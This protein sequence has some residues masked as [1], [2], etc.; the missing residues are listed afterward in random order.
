LNLEW[1]EDRTLLSGDTL[2]TATSIKFNADHAT[3]LAGALAFQLDVELVSMNLVA[4]DTVTTAVKPPKDG[5]GFDSYVRVFNP[6][7]KE[8]AASSAYHGKDPGLTFQAPSAGTYF[9]GI[10]DV[11]NTN[12]DPTI[13]PPTASDDSANLSFDLKLSKKK[14]PLLP[15]LVGRSFHIA[16]GAVVW[17]DSVT[18]N[19]EIENRGGPP[20]GPFHVELRLSAD[21]HIDSDAS[22]P[23]VTSWRVSALAAGAMTAGTLHVTLPATPEQSSPDITENGTFYLGL[24]IDP[25]NAVQESDPSSSA[26]Q[27]EG[28]DRGALTVL[29]AVPEKGP[30]NTTSDA[31]ALF[32]AAGP[33]FGH[34]RTSRALGPNEAA[35]YQFTAGTAAQLTAQ[36][37]ASG[38]R[39]RLSLLDATGQL[40][41]QSDGQSA[42]NPESIIQLYLPHSAKGDTFYLR[43]QWLAGGTGTYVF[44]TQLVPGSFPFDPLLP[45]PAFYSAVAIGDFNGDGIPDLAIADEFRNPS[46]G[47]PASIEL[48]LGNKDASGNPDG[49]F[50]DVAPL[51]L[52]VS[53]Q[54]KVEVTALVAGDFIGNGRSDL[55]AAVTD[56][57]TGSAFLVV[58]LARGDGT[59]KEL[60]QLLLGQGQPGDGA[61]VFTLGVGDL[62]GDG[63]PDL[64]VV[65][66]A[67]DSIPIDLLFGN[68]D[69]TFREAP[70]GPTVNG[71]IDAL[72]VGSVYGDGHADLVAAVTTDPVGGSFALVVLRGNGNGTFMAAPPIS[73]PADSGQPVALAAADF[74]GSGH[75]DLAIAL[76][77]NTNNDQGTTA[78]QV[79]AGNG[80]GTFTP[81]DAYPFPPDQ[82]LDALAAG[83]FNGDGLT[84]LAVVN[85]AGSSSQYGLTL[86]QGKGDGSFQNGAFV[87]AGKDPGAA[88]SADFNGDGRPDLAIA[89]PL[90]H[91]IN[92]FLGD[93]M[94]SF[95]PVVPYP[96]PASVANDVVEVTALVA[97]DFNG[98]GHPD[99][100]ATIKDDTTH[101]AY[102]AVLLGQGDGSFKLSKWEALAGDNP[103]AVAAGDFND[104]GFTDLAVLDEASRSIEVLLGSLDGSLGSLK[105]FSVGRD[106]IALVAGDF[107]GRHFKDGTPIL[108]LA[109]ADIAGKNAVQVLLGGGD[110]SFQQGESIPI[111]GQPRALVTG[112][113]DDSHD[114]DGTPVLDLAV[115]YQ[116]LHPAKNNSNAIQVLLGDGHGSFSQAKPIAVQG[117][118]TVLVA[119]DFTGRYY[120][121]GTPVLD[122]VAGDRFNGMIHVLLGTEIGSFN[123]ISQTFPTGTDVRALVAAPFAGDGTD[124]LAITTAGGIVVRLGA[125]DG[126]LVDPSAGPPIQSTPLVADINHD[127]IPDLIVLNRLGQILVRYGDPAA[128]GGFAAPIIINPD[129]PARDLALVRTAAGPVLAAVD[130]TAISS[131]GQQAEGLVSLY[132][133][134]ANGTLLGRIAE[135][136]VP[137][138]SYLTRIAANDFQGH[139][140]DDIVVLASR[141]DQAFVFLQNGD[142]GFPVRPTYNLAT[143]ANPVDLALVDVNGDHRPDLVVVDKSSGDLTVFINQVL[144]Q[145]N[146]R[147]FDQEHE[148]RFPA[149]PGPYGLEGLRLGLNVRSGQGTTSIV[150]GGG[151]DLIAANSLGGNLAR[152]ASDGM[153]GFFGPQTNGLSGQ[154][155]PA[156]VV[157]VYM[158][159]PD[160]AGLAVLNVP[161]TAAGNAPPNSLQLFAQRPNG[162]QL[163]ATLFAGNVPTGLA[164]ADA[165]GDHVPD[166]LAGNDYGDI[167]VFAGNGAGTFQPYY[168]VS[169]GHE[170]VAL[171]LT[172]NG[173][174]FG[175]KAQ[176][177]VT[178]SSG[179]QRAAPNF[180]QGRANGILAPSA[181]QVADLNGDGIPDLIVANSGT[182]QLFV[183]PGLGNGRFEPTPRVVSTGGVDP[184]TLTV[185]DVNNDGIP[186]VIVANLQSNNVSVLL[187]SGRGTQWQLQPGQLVRA[188]QGPDATLVQDVTKDGIP[189]LLVGNSLS[190]DVFILPGLGNGRFDDRHPIIIPNID[191]PAQLFAGH[192]NGDPGIQ[193]ASVNAD[194][195]T[196]ISDPAGAHPEVTLHTG[197]LARAV[198]F[199]LAGFSDLLLADTDG[200]FFLLSG[201]PEGLGEPE[202]LPGTL[203]HPSELA[204]ADLGI[205]FVT[206]DA[207]QEGVDGV[208]QLQFGLPVLVSPLPPFEGTAALRSATLGQ[209]EVVLQPF[210]PSNLGTIPIPEVALGSFS[211]S[212]EDTSPTAEPGRQEA[213]LTGFTLESTA[214]MAALLALQADVEPVAPALQDFLLEKGPP[215][216]LPNPGP[217]VDEAEWLDGP[218]VQVLRPRE[219]VIGAPWEAVVLQAAAGQMGMLDPAPDQLRP[220]ERWA[221]APR[222]AP[223]STSV[224]N[225]IRPDAIAQPVGTSPAGE[226]P[227]ARSAV[228]FLVSP[229][230][231]NE[232][233]ARQTW[234][235]G[236]SVVVAVRPD[237]PGL[238]LATAVGL[239]TIYHAGLV[240]AGD[241]RRN[242]ASRGIIRSRRPQPWSRP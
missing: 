109:V 47:N 19:Y 235:E 9:V 156:V 97:G 204:L 72:V 225:V 20:A 143:G 228:H 18:I 112:N 174:V 183:Y 171:A 87:P 138:E 176:D 209:P 90:G 134:A 39:A 164:V 29:G 92:V 132:G 165:T 239:L 184:V 111:N 196:L 163:L 146:A 106:P 129:A 51:L 218:I 185:A 101:A 128:A 21:N 232:P 236:S 172:G 237:S 117:Q 113:F 104:D 145:A 91:A 8:I 233:T 186:D 187:G 130:V 75:L 52:S 41:M 98:D 93:G 149:G 206:I 3:T 234:N 131:D 15:E 212:G 190:N 61:P 188:G 110:G 122:L 178:V 166:L 141:A 27:G 13:P 53:S 36:V 105:R 86:L 195:V 4:G 6:A 192:F 35:Y 182:D 133:W 102:L 68:G 241:G 114:V 135:L 79:F 197:D 216:P 119:G 56:V 226:L 32:P 38:F 96:F 24:L 217:T 193:L 11:N 54:G 50:A 137:G 144:T 147:L 148:E 153:G 7:G 16:R 173:F 150:A 231:E 23:L 219:S 81:L 202:L 170:P 70:Q 89:D 2:S 69:G 203:V 46:E 167:L 22:D 169:D 121:D 115:A 58:L 240:A 71:R 49:S 85:T 230:Q 74:T 152:L 179:L 215:S 12:Y 42:A 25:G 10:S 242:R 17:G 210:S 55:A 40:L 33:K 80:D 65:E 168:R 181:V 201:G 107:T 151:G 76:N 88:V 205:N 59:F 123:L 213:L 127:G 191:N 189:D 95:T 83:D 124:D 63:I 136:T 84:D 67:T 100:A 208:M 229:S 139:G 126:T 57:V 48:R 175:D 37:T 60:P 43:M 207:T 198:E 78:V 211:Q 5:S 73:L 64:A 1:L 108:D 31:T 200:G 118:A 82:A 221:A 154:S 66:K 220:G 199:N 177:E 142:G 14:E 77:A 238:P 162:Y 157:S 103:G 30:N 116:S 180:A 45:G 194:S 155:S 120:S 222:P 28:I 125:G 34:A 44:D 223:A 158:G 214:D 140:L 160:L 26:N 99:L 224:V 62:N 159:N 161:R 94:G 227:W